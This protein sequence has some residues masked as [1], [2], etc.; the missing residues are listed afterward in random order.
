MSDLIITEKTCSVCKTLKLLTEFRKYSGRSKGGVRPLCKICQREY[1]KK[2]RSSSK[3]YRA[4]QRQQRRDKDR[5]YRQKYNMENKASLLVSECRRRCKKKNIPFDLDQ[6]IEEI[7][8]R[9]SMGLCEVSGFPLNTTVC[10][11]RPFNT[12]SLDRINPK[13]GYLYNNIRIV[14]FAVNA[15]MGDWGED[16]FKKIMKTWME[17]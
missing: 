8:N 11:G 5:A 3:E 12:P 16:A 1:E 13:D 7:Q 14:A 17:K 2:W 4:A 15:A 10:A 6:H 9:I